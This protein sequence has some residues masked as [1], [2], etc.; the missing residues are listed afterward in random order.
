MSDKADRSGEAEQASGQ[1]CGEAEFGVDD[2]GG[3]V[4]VHGDG[5]AFLLVEL[6]LQLPRDGG[7]MALNQPGLAGIIHQLQ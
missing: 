5:F 2:G 7:V 1:G 6:A 3:A 4:D